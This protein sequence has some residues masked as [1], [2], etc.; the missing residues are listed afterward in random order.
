[1]SRGTPQRGIRIEE[2]LWAEVK[3]RAD[4]EGINVSELVRQLLR[5]WLEKS[6]DNKQGEK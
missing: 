5:G 6:E 1:M 4:T 3:A 2:D